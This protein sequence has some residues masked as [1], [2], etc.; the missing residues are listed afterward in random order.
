VAGS[1]LSWTDGCANL[2]STDADRAFDQRDLH[3]LP[4]QHRVPPVPAAQHDDA[5]AKRQTGRQ[6]LFS[7]LLSRV[8]HNQASRPA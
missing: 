3:V 5:A 8:D 1:A 4:D 2:A 6:Q 7:Q